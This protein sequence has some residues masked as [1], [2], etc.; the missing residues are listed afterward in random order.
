MATVQ[1]NTYS[2]LFGQRLGRHLKMASQTI[3]HVSR[4]DRL[5]L[6]VTRLTCMRQERDRTSSIEP[7]AAFNVTYRLKDVEEHEFWSNGRMRY[8]R[9]FAAGTVNAIDLSEDPRSRARGPVDALQFYMRKEVLDDLAYERGASPISTLRSLP[10]ASDPIL[11]SM[12]AFLLSA[13]PEM[14]QTNQLF[15]DQM[16]LS[17]L[18]YFAEGY[19]GMHIP[20]IPPN[21]SLAA[22]QERRAKEILHSRLAARLAIADVARECNLTPS[23]FAKAFRR[24]TGMSPHQY[25]THIRLEEAKGL[26]LSSSLPLADI[27]LICGF[28]DQSYF[29]RVFTRSVGASP[30]AWRRS[31]LR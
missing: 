25:L 3:L 28:G 1:E 27:A 11:G 17:L 31:M 9:G 22:W 5:S 2:G 10:D 20:P 18:T 30:G 29:T 6:A 16:A 13:P 12:C 26:L 8:V 15:V 19:G 21:G 24:T 7:E 4:E 14:A 23:Y